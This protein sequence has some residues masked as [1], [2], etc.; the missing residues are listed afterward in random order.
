MSRLQVTMFIVASIDLI[1]L[2]M[3]FYIEHTRDGDFICLHF[4]FNLLA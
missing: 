1:N 3:E 2:T 4:S